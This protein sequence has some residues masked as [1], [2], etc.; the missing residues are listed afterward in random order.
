MEGKYLEQYLIF[1]HILPKN[2][3][4]GISAKEAGYIRWDVDGKLG[5]WEVKEIEISIFELLAAAR[6]IQ[7]TD[8]VDGDGIMCGK[9]YEKQTA[10]MIEFSSLNG[11][12]GLAG[13]SRYHR[14]FLTDDGYRQALAEEAKGEIR[15][16][17]Y[18]RLNGSA[19]NYKASRE[20]LAAG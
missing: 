10:H 19:L 20:E 6:E 2:S 5:D 9:R 14:S 13:K 17:R 4:K 12:E 11:K 8:Y 16:I 15:I 3:I 1:L 18:A 7:G